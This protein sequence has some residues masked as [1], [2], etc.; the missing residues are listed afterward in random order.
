MF[1]DSK[2]INQFVVNLITMIGL[3]AFYLSSKVSLY[4]RSS[5]I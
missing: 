1:G 5:S 3:F 4:L 2:S